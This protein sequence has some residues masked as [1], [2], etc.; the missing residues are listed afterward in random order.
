MNSPH[1][2]GAPVARQTYKRLG[3]RCEG[4]CKVNRDWFLAWVVRNPDKY[5]AQLERRRA[6]WTSSA[7]AR[8]NTV[9]R[10][11]TEQRRRLVRIEQA[12]ARGWTDARIIRELDVTLTDVDAAWD[13]ISGEAAA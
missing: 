1:V 10:E 3:C 7:K 5:A 4:C 9:R 12:I 6:K 11:A 2:E 13:S 8:A